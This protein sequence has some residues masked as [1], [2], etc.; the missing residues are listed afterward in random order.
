MKGNPNIKNYPLMVVFTKRFTRGAFS[1]MEVKS[2]LP[3]VDIRSA[4]DWISGVRS[5]IRK[6]KLDFEFASDPI[7]VDRKTNREVPS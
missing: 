1:G 5:N 4:E 7:V 6:G 3:C 2:Y